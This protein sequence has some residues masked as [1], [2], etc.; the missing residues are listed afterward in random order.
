[1]NHPTF[2]FDSP[3]VFA[4][5]FHP[6]PEGTGTVLAGGFENLTVPVENGVT[7]GGRFYRAG[8][9][10]PTVLFF[11]G[12]GEIVADYAELAKVYTRM[13]I[14]FMPIDYRGYGRSSGSPT[15]TTMLKD[16]QQAFCFARQ[17]LRDH[18]YA[19]RFVAMGRSLGSASALELAS[20]HT[21]EIDALIIHGTHDTIIPVAD[22]EALY[23]AS[24]SV[25]KKLLRIRGAGHN[26]L[27][28]VGPDEYFQSVSNIVQ[29]GTQTETGK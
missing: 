25:T 18:G 29:H 6:R 21:N 5:I 11:H 2:S 4:V 19:G 9:N 14:N 3:A 13:G 22:A 7:I 8:T 16:A 15:V 28:A 20:S 1:M 26:N 27:L 17:W 24:G 23:Q 10:N 12:N